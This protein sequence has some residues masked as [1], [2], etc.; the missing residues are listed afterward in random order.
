MNLLRD[1]DGGERDG[2]EGL[3]ISDGVILLTK[4]TDEMN[5]SLW[6]LPIAARYERRWEGVPRETT[7][8]ANC[9]VTL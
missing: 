2:E 4:W 5:L 1:P 3:K 8:R 7:R 9:S 6:V